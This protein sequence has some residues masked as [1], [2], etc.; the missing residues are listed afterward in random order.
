MGEDISARK[1]DGVSTGGTSPQIKSGEIMMKTRTIGLTIGTAIAALCIAIAAV[2][3]AKAGG[4]Y[5][6]GHGG[7][8]VVRTGSAPRYTVPHT[9]TTTVKHNTNKDIVK[10]CREYFFGTKNCAKW[11]Y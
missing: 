11:S 2:P 6:N 8:A 5:V 7:G 3:E 1:S 9:Y 10:V 4:V